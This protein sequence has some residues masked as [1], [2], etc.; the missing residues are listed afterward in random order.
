MANSQQRKGIWIRLP[1][2]LKRKSASSTKAEVVLPET[3]SEHSE[4]NLDASYLQ[5]DTTKVNSKS[6]AWKKKRHLPFTDTIKASRACTNS[7]TES[8]VNLMDSLSAEIQLEVFSMLDLTSIRHMMATNRTFRA[9]LVSDSAYQMWLSICQTKFSM[10][11]YDS[12]HGMF[13][14]DDFSLPMA[15]SDNAFCRYNRVNLPLLLSMTPSHLPT[16]MDESNPNMEHFLFGNSLPTD[17]SVDD[18]KLDNSFESSFS[19]T[20]SSDIILKLFDYVGSGQVYSAKANHP[21]PRPNLRVAPKKSNKMSILKRSRPVWDPMVIPY[22]AL[23]DAPRLV[24]VTPRLVSYFEISITKSPDEATR[25]RINLEQLDQAQAQECIVIGLVTQDSS[26]Q[27]TL[28]GWDMA[29]FG[30]HS[31]NGGLYHGSG[32]AQQRT[33]AFGPGDTVGMGV[34]YLARTIF[35]TKNGRFLGSAYGIFSLDFLAAEDLYP[36]VGMDSK[37]TVHVNYGGVGKPFHFN[38]PSYCH[39]QQ[40]NMVPAKSRVSRKFRFSN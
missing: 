29:S 21:L 19:S 6:K 7:T 5:G 24:H 32:H 23:A 14:Q 9:L 34:D 11:D 30:Y 26:P 17:D 25:P 16:G 4:E 3:A 13:L 37:D 39:R 33:E 20:P 28:P 27:D 38:L 8:Q 10:Q 35:V 36:V 15:V 1:L 2:K 18:A 40:Q 22:N 12:E 31:D